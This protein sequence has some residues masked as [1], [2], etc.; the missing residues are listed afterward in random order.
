MAYILFI[1]LYVCLWRGVTLFTAH[2]GAIDGP[3]RNV[4]GR[5]VAMRRVNEQAHLRS[6]HIM[7]PYR[8]SNG[9]AARRRA[10]RRGVVKGIGPAAGGNKHTARRYLC[11]KR[12]RAVFDRGV[13]K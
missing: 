5:R 7:P 11:P 4:G 3:Q 9:G 2:T 1:I 12:Y 8:N 13:S 6:A 10:C